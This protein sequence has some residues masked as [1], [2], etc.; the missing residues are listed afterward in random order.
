MGNNKLIQG[1]V[2]SLSSGFYDIYLE[3]GREVVCQ[4]RGRLKKRRRDEVRGDIIAMGDQVLVAMQSDGSGAIEEVLP[5][6]Q[7]LI[8]SA[9]DAR[10]EYKQVLLANPDQI[11]LVF[12][13]AQPEPHLRMLD[14]FLVICEQQG[15]DVLIAANKV[16]L[17]GEQAA[18]DLFGMYQQIG[19]EVVYTS[20]V[21]G[22]G[23]D[24]LHARLRDRLSGLVGPSGVGKSSLL[25]AIQPALGLAIRNVSETTSKGRHTTVVRRL[26]PLDVGGFVADLPGI[27]M[28]SLWDIEPEELDGYFPEISVR[29]ADCQFSDCSHVNEP[30][31]AIKAAVTK[32]EIHYARYESYLR[33][34]YGDVDEW[35]EEID[36]G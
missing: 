26:F 20:S 7:A 32:G 22:L 28:L 8:R 9:P 14:R 16:D 17:V 34:R 33:M 4:P 31:C 29:V 5:R 6:K 25:N 35:I 2:M 18:H 36:L 30:G 10:G 1:R 23:L 11:V 24:E 12:S 27:R 19:Y 21:S 3:D 13:C 15:I